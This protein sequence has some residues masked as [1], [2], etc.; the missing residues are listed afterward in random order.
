MDGVAERAPQA[1]WAYGAAA[2]IHEVQKDIAD[3]LL[4]VYAIEDY[5]S[6]MAMVAL[7]VIRPGLALNNYQTQYLSSW[8]SKFWPYAK[9]SPKV[10]KKF[11]FSK[12]R[13]AKNARKQHKLAD[14]AVLSMPLY[15]R[16][17]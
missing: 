10:A 12:R 3:A 17:S 11:I 15:G 4:K 7:R 5:E 8:V 6:I 9:L 16:S 13:I 14:Y 2:L 1:L